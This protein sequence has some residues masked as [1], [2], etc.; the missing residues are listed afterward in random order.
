MGDIWSTFSKMVNNCENH[1][2]SSNDTHSKGGCNLT[3]S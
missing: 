2:H 1:V 3:L